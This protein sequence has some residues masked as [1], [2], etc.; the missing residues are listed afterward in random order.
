M[1]R[2]PSRMQVNVQRLS[3]VLVELQIE[4]G[5]DRVKVEVD[6]AYGTLAK[7][8]KVRG[9]RPGK[10]P[11]S[12]LAH[13]FGGRVASDVAQRIIDET[14]PEAIKQNGLQPI[15]AAD[16][17]R[18]E[19][20]ADNQPFTYKVRFEV[21]PAIET[22]SYDG[23]AAKRPQ[24]D[25]T[26]AEV[27][28]ELE[29][30][31]LNMST[32]EAPAEERPSKKGDVLTIDL[33]VEVGGKKVNEAGAS[34]LQAEL[35][36]GNLIPAVDEAL[37]GHLPGDVVSV[38]VDMPVQHPLPALRGRRAKLTIQVRDLKE[39]ILPNADD[40]F[41]RDAGSFQTID[42]LKA[43]L[44]TKLEK[45]EEERA[46][47]TVA[48]QLVLELVKANPIPVPSSLVEQQMRIT[49]QEILAQ[50]RRQGQ[51]AESLAP[52]MREHVR[53]D[54]EIKVRAG[55]LM[56]EIAK[57]QGIKIGDPEIEDG[58]KELAEQ[59]GKNLAKVRAEH[60]DP[61]KREM[62]IGMILE[63]KVLDII[64]SK[65]KIEGAPPSP[66]PEPPP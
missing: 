7:S 59:T 26:E 43:D 31:R 5:A 66:S 18:P 46:A 32:L 58:M 8:A 53:T 51:A 34:A 44:R 29:K 19:R 56:A 50:A 65:A 36:G 11:R 10:A 64:E 23:L 13:V 17:G 55:L 12:V 6:K 62:L 37:L 20:V 38:E 35:G 45:A 63:N 47:N 49:E 14:F 33:A 21:L 40:E 3:P 48:E 61:K 9:F 30:L 1:A 54:S 22:V 42:E 4:V 41:A 28:A 24:V 60:A 39:R 16:F 15:S 27:E 57:Q 25:V 2:G 52:D